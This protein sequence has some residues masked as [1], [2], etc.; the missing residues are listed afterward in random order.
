MFSDCSGECC[1]C[2][3]G[4]GCLAGHGDDDYTPA[5]KE[6]VIRRLQKGEYPN[7]R[8]TMIKYVY[9]YDITSI[10]FLSSAIKIFPVHSEPIIVYGF[11]HPDCLETIYKLGISRNKNDDIQGFII[12]NENNLTETFVDRYEGAKI[13]IELGYVLEYPNCLYSEDI[14]PE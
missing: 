1:I 8:K 14:W 5:S 6:Q 13:A 4:D 3:C 2:A 11:R 9:G 10:K 7:Y 12:L